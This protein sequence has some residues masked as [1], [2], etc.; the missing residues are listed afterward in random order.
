MCVCVCVH[1]CVHTHLCV[2]VFLCVG[3]AGTGVTEARIG[4]QSPWSWSYS[5]ELPSA[6][7]GN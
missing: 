3:H 5:C 2:C 1:V 4:L 6:G 7:A